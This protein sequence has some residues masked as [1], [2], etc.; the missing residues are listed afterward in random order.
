MINNYLN[1]FGLIIFID[2]LYILFNNKYEKSTIFKC[3]YNK[4]IYINIV[5]RLVIIFYHFLF[6]F[7]KDKIIY[8][9]I[10]FY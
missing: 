6:Y 2:T 1:F 8:E 4:Y 9:F 10:Q 5:I 3:K 7:K